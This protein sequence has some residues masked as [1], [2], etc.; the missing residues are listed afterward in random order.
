[1][2]VLIAMLGRMAIL[3]GASVIQTALFYAV[4]IPPA[5]AFYYA[6]I[7]AWDAIILQAPIVFQRVYYIAGLGTMLQ[8]FTT[9]LAS[10]ITAKLTS[11][12]FRKIL[13]SLK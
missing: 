12:V 2:P 1:M 13:G 8:M 5:I 10:G 9:S 6:S 4:L 3:G 7:V 11:G